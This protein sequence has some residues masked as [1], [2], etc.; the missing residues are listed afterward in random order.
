M[1]G[2]WS[3]KLVCKIVSTKNLH[4]FKFV[5]THKC[6]KYSCIKNCGYSQLVGTQICEY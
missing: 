6:C 3:A 2:C 1:C 5:G 4:V